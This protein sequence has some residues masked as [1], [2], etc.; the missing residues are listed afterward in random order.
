[1]AKSETFINEVVNY[2][3]DTNSTVR[4]TAEHF[5]ISKSSVHHYLTVIM[6][7]PKSREILD[8]NKAERHMRGGLALKAKFEKK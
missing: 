7:N 3:N 5:D 1:M 4:K 6:P 2:F 8:K